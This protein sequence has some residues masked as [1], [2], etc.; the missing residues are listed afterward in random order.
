MRHYLADLGLHVNGFLL[1]G[2]PEKYY[3]QDIF[4]KYE[5]DQVLKHK[6]S[7][8]SMIPVNSRFART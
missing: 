2:G 4:L 1:V 6:I 3:T 5:T 8:G 7:S